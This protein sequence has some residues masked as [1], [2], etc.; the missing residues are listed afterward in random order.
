MKTKITI[1]C[2]ALILSLTAGAQN[3]MNINYGGT[4]KREGRAAC[5]GGK[6]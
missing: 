6:P 5:H 1:L 4:P 2:M 3:K